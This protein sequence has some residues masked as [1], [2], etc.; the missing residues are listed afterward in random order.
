VIPKRVSDKL[1]ILGSSA[2]SLPAYLNDREAFKEY[3]S[4]GLNNLFGVVPNPTRWFEI[5]RIWKEKGVWYRRGKSEQSVDGEKSS[6]KKYLERLDSL[7]VPVLMHEVNPLIEKSVEF[8]FKEIMDSFPF[9][10]YTCTMAWQMGLAILMGFKRIEFYGMDL[11]DYWE[12]RYQ[13]ACLAYWIGVATGRGIDVRMSLDST[14]MR[15]PFLYG[16]EKENYY[17]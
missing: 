14:F 5:H 2:L 6:I 13:R 12:R 17:E 11:L 1:V 8:P 3:E 10:F 16:F 9:H 4:W 15:S 7:K